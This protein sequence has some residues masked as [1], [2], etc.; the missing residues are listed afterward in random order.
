VANTEMAN[1]SDSGGYRPQFWHVIAID[2]DGPPTKAGVAIS[3]GTKRT[4]KFLNLTFDKYFL[5]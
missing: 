4:L 5:P 3:T 2:W 1:F